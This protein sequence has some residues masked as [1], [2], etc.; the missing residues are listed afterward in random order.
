MGEFN[1]GT[2]IIVRAGVVWRGAGTLAV[3]LIGIKL[4]ED[5]K[6]GRQRKAPCVIMK[7]NTWP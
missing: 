5:E 3:A 4:R 7:K 1:E 6:K 2:V